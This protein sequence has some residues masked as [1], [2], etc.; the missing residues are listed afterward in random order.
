MNQLGFPSEVTPNE[1]ASEKSLGG[2]IGLC[3]KA[4]GLEP[5]QVQDALKTD[6]A[7]FSRWTDDKEGIVWSKF[8]ALM[9]LCGNDAPLLWML[10]Q[11]GFD[12]TSLRKR[13]TETEKKLRLA[14]ERIQQLERE[15]EVERRL[16]R[17][18]RTAA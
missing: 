6:K 8:V 11:R 2:A 10:D 14:E 7:Q 17:D 18:L 12:L 1:I 4:A 3:A 16:F 13:E 9:D 15:R 5:K